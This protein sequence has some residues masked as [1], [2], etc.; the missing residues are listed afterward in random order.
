MIGLWII[1]IQFNE[2]KREL[3]LFASTFERKIWK[4]YHK[5]GVIQIKQYYNVKYLGCLLDETMFEEARTH[6]VVN[7]IN[8]KLKFLFW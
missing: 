5:Y 1:N 6:N 4:Y 8:N 7:K 2:D 3:K